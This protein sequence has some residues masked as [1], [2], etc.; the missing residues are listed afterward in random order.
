MILLIYLKKI[1]EKL[2]VGLLLKYEKK[3]LKLYYK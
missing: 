1:V 3:F 2:V